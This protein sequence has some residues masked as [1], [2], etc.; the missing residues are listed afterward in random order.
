VVTAGAGLTTLTADQ[1]CNS[2]VIIG[3]AATGNVGIP[4]SAAIDAVLG[5]GDGYTFEF[6]VINR[7]PTNAL[8]LASTEIVSQPIPRAGF[9]GHSATT[10]FYFKRIAGVW[11]PLNT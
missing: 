4:L 8:V 3:A 1:F 5:V 6:K 7:N 10:T 9:A 11:T 2:V